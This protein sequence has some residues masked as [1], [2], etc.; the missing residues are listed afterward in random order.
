MTTPDRLAFDQE[1]SLFLA[2]CRTATLATVDAQGAPCAANVQYASD[3]DFRLLWVSSPNSV[4]SE[5]L[6]SEPRVALTAYAHDD[7]AE[8]IH[9]LQMRGVASAL[10]PRDAPP[11]AFE[12]YTAKFAFLASN[13]QLRAAVEKQRFYAFTPTWLRWIDNRVRFGHK[14]EMTLNASLR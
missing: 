8:N 5:N 14:V 3:A 11:Q 10:E 13:P 4:H 12:Q 2:T 7:R 9:G 1:V 6:Q